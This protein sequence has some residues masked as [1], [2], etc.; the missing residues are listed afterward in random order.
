L[1]F[2]KEKKMGRALKIQKTN[3][4][5]GTSVSGS[6]T[7]YNQNILTDAGYPPFSALTN[8]AYNTPVQTLND[9]EY[10]GVV[11]GS[12]VTSTASATYPE[13]AALVN[14]LLAD[15]SNTFSLAS[16]YTGRIIRQKG[17][18]KFLVAYTGGTYALSS[19]LIV[20]QS[21][22]IVSL[23]TSDWSTILS[24]TA[25]VGRIFTA[26]AAGAGNGTVY[27]VG[28]C[29][30]S[31]T[32]TPSAGNMSISYSVGD[33]AAVYASYITNKWVRDWNGMT[34]GNYS[35]SNL[36]VNVQSA[37]NFYP[38]NFFTDEGSVTWSGAEVIGGAQS[39]NGTLQLA[40]IASVTS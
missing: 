13:V 5:S 6:T 21:Y 37:E 14:I 36:G 33:S 38:T 32:A 27:P 22:Q 18:H 28:Q 19:G 30:L 9:T 4:G 10:L 16:S 31:N 17:A 7:S 29:V 40:Q 39:Q 23:G 24:G 15:G 3:T 8:P 26:L 11:G 34:V 25:A 20:G 35:N 12:P 2:F 1:G